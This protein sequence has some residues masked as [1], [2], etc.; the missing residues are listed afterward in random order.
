MLNTI[1][2]IL[3]MLNTFR[4]RNFKMD[5]DRIVSKPKFDSDYTQPVDF[6]TLSARLY[7]FVIFS[8]FTT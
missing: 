2:Q 7:P 3:C 4:L 6:S 1:T 5:V 8:Q